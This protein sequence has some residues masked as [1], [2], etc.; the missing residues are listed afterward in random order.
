MLNSR[1]CSRKKYYFLIIYIQIV[2]VYTMESLLIHNELCSVT[3]QIILGN[4]TYKSMPM[5][6]IS[7]EK[8]Y[9]SSKKK[10]R[11]KMVCHRAIW[12]QQWRL[13]S[14]KKTISNGLKSVHWRWNLTLGRIECQSEKKNRSNVKT[15][16]FLVKYSHDF[17]ETFDNSWSIVLYQQ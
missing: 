11:W 9:F 3:E 15:S 7:F 14:R 13:R 17:C 1:D 2:V 10:K 4:K 8:F 12:Q 6:S 16:D 5:S